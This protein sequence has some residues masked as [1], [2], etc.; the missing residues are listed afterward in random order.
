MR[1][2]SLHDIYP[3]QITKAIAEALREFDR[4][5][6]GE[7]LGVTAMLSLSVSWHTPRPQRPLHP[8]SRFLIAVWLSCGDE[9]AHLGLG[10][11]QGPRMLGLSLAPPS[12]SQVRRHQRLDNVVV[13]KRSISL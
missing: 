5:L 11:H 13:S 4:R 1:P 10:W 2:S 9:Q 12:L 6:P 3:P 7:A 8:Y